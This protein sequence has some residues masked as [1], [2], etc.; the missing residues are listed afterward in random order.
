MSSWAEVKR[1]VSWIART[2]TIHTSLPLVTLLIRP[3]FFSPLA[4]AVEAWPAAFDDCA[5]I[6][7]FALIAQLERFT[8]GVGLAV[9]EGWARR[10]C[11]F[12]WD[13]LVV[14]AGAIGNSDDVCRLA[15]LACEGGASPC[16]VFFQGAEFGVVD[17]N[18]EVWAVIK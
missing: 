11:W 6:D 17:G 2:V 1:L 18:K 10:G 7:A 3:T 12:C 4:F 14:N 5:F 8:I 15:G 9:I 16:S 13:W